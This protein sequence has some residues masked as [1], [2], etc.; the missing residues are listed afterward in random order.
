MHLKMPYSGI[1]IDLFAAA[2]ILFVMVTG[3]L[4]FVKADPCD[5]TYKLLCTNKHEQ[6]WKIHEINKKNVSESFVDLMNCMLAFDPTQRLS[7]SEI[8][9]HKWLKG[10]TLEKNEIIIEMMARKKTIE[11][12]KLVLQEKVEKTKIKRKIGEKPYCLNTV[13]HEKKFRNTEK[14]EIYKKS[15]KKRIEPKNLIEVF[16]F[17]FN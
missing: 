3:K 14:N 10:K 9:S 16:F 7:I 11:C 6:F 15:K 4:P 12:G 1:I 8:E 13:N 5:R 17:L 2:I